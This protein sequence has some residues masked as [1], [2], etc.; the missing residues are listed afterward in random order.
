M[1]K[2]TG[3]LIRA[4]FALEDDK[5]KNIPI[6]GDYFCFPR[7][8]IDRLTTKLEDCPLDGIPKVVEDFYQIEKF[9]LVCYKI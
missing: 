9:E 3:G 1:H 6:S 4:D 8:V 5:L 7:D 2:A